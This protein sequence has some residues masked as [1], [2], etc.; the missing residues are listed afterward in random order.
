MKQKKQLHKTGTNT[1]TAQAPD[2]SEDPSQAVSTGPE[3]PTT[4][5]PVFFFQGRRPRSRLPVPV[6]SCAFRARRHALQ[7]HKAV[8]DVAQ[9]HLIRRSGDSQGD[10]G[11]VTSKALG[12]KR[13][14]LTDAHSYLVA[15]KAETAGQ[16]GGGVR[17]EALGHE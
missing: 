12:C 16:R 3:W 5:Q 6:V 1:P 15:S 2:T 14:R 10:N 7:L 9:G 4:G 13:I 11:C 8:D 17:R